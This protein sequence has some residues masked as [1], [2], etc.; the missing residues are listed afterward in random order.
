MNTFTINE[1]INGNKR[2]N[3]G[4]LGRNVNNALS[5]KVEKRLFCDFRE[6]GKLYGKTKTS[7]KQKNH[8]QPPVELL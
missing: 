1:S 4:F 2:G 8:N 5:L 7:F 3:T 6:K